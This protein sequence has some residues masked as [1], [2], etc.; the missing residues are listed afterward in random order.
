MKWFIWTLLGVFIA[1]QPSY[2]HP[3]E[4]FQ[5]LEVLATRINGIKGS[6]PWEFTPVHSAR[7][8]VPIYI[9]Y[10][11]IF[12]FYGTL[13]PLWILRLIRLQ[14]FG[15]YF[16]VSRYALNHLKHSGGQAEFMLQSSYIAWCHQSHSF[17]NSLETLLVLIALSLYSDLM[18]T[19]YGKHAMVKSA[20]LSVV[21]TLGIFNRITFPV[22]LLLPSI[23]LFFKFYIRSRRSLMVLGLTLSLST[24]SFIYVDTMIYGGSHWI[25]APWN[26]FKYNLDESNLAQHGLHPRYTHILVNLP[27]LVGPAILFIQVPR[28]SLRGW[29]TDIPVLSVFSGLAL[30]SVFKH[31]ELRFLIPLAPLTLMSL[32]LNKYWKTYGLKVW[33]GFNIIMA[34][35]MGVLHQ[36]GIVPL[37]DVMRE[38]PLGVHIWW[39]TYSPPTWMYANSE[40]ISSTTNFVDNVEKVDNVPFS[41]IH[42]HVVDLKGCDEKLLNHTLNQFL[43]QNT[44]VQVIAPDS[45]AHRLESLQDSYQFQSLQ[46]WPLHL[47]LDHINLSSKLLGITRYSVARR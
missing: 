40:L 4:H 15:L 41:S 16:L 33:I 13:S 11:W 2:I 47:D 23:V 35:V 34:T 8:F 5:S 19:P 39:K 22:F 36:G 14:H 27:Q 6:I 38:E 24:L 45:V 9:S 21:V 32:K 43:L 30:L 20:V 26:N 28:K 10:W 46:S 37:L 3:D 12:Q 1:L 18:Q 42:D 31:Q 29:F 7:S 17:S 44:N 25:I